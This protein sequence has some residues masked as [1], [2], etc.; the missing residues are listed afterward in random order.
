MSTVT[1]NP[2]TTPTYTD[3]ALSRNWWML[4]LRGV[5]A[6]LFGIL[7]IAWPGIAAQ[8]LILVFGAYVFVD[9]IFAIISAF[10][11]RSQSHWWVTLLEG[12]VG[13]I[14]GILTFI[15]PGLTALTL[16]TL[17]GVWAVFTGVLQMVTAFRLR[18][19]IDN[20]WAMGLAGLASLLFGLFV[21]FAPGAGAL[22][23]LGLIAGY[24]I[25]FGVL[26]LILAFR[27]KDYHPATSQ[28]EATMRQRTL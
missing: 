6:I 3:D 15:L 25:V 19:T 28:T 13:V 20:E 7:I 11:H 22:A 12:I 10:Q 16:L 4:A 8:S 17:I 23:V 24:S 21:L 27:V 1:N 18:A 5:L 9:G 14:A 2:G 26:L